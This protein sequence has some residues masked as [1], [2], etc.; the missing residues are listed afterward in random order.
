MTSL[1]KDICWQPFST[2]VNKQKKKKQEQNKD[3][4]I[5][6]ILKWTIEFDF[7]WLFGMNISKPTANCLKILLTDKPHGLKRIL[8]IPKSIYRLQR[9]LLSSIRRW[10]AWDIESLNLFNQNWKPTVET[11]ITYRQCILLSEVDGKQYI[12]SVMKN[13]FNPLTLPVVLR[14][15]CEEIHEID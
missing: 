12:Q 14:K 9:R 6:Y 13:C 10:Q 4:L 2:H 3:K 15:L 11:H 5:K 7:C 1:E 8:L